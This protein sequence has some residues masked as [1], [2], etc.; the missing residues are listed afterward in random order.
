[1]KFL[2]LKEAIEKVIP[3][4][5]V[6][7]AK[8]ELPVVPFYNPGAKKQTV[9]GGELLRTPVDKTAAMVVR[10]APWWAKAPD[11]PMPTEQVPLTESLPQ[12]PKSRKE[13]RKGMSQSPNVHKTTN[14]A[15]SA[16][17][18]IAD[19][20]TDVFNA[21]LHNELIKRG[22]KSIDGSEDLLKRALDARAALDVMADSWKVSWM[23]FVEQSDARLLSLRQTRMAFDTE[24]RLLMS[25]LREVRQFFLDKNH[26]EEVARLK[27]F[28]DL[29]ERLQKLKESGFLDTVA[30]TLIK[31]T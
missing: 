2:T 20:P 18:E 11:M 23:E 1:M 17:T 24:T 4:F 26:S 16:I 13:K 30:D 29:C 3:K 21:E 22:A 25:S 10:K 6:P 28:V 15:Q 14:P 27:E 7:E 12:Q 9:V 31:L 19:K 8:P 5:K